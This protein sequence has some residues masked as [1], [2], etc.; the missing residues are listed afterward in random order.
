MTSTATLQM[1]QPQM[2]Q[3]KMAQMNGAP[4]LPP[5]PSSMLGKAPVKRRNSAT[6]ETPAFVRAIEGGGVVPEGE[7]VHLETSYTPIN[8]NSLQVDWYKDG[9]PVNA[10]SR[11]NTVIDRGYAVLDILYTLVEDSGEYT[12]VAKSNAGTAQS[13]PT[14]IS[15][16]EEDNVISTSMLPDQGAQ[17]QELDA[18]WTSPKHAAGSED[19][20]PK[21]APYFSVQLMPQLNLIENQPAHFETKIE[22]AGDSALKVEWYKDGQLLSSSCRFNVIFDRGFAILEIAYCFPE[23]SGD[24]YCVATNA[25][26]QAQS[27]VVQLGCAGGE[28]ILTTSNLPEQSVNHLKRFDEPYDGHSNR[29]YEEDREVAAPTFQSELGPPQLTIR[30]SA[31]ARF[32]VRV[33]PGSGDN[34]TVEWFHDGERVHTGSRILSIC[35]LG[36]V[37][38]VFQYVFAEDSGQYMCV[39]STEYG[40]VP[41]NPVTLQCSAEASI[42]TDSQLPGNAEQGI[43]AIKTLEEELNRPRENTYTYAEPTDAPTFVKQIAEP[44]SPIPESRPVGFDVRVEP[45]D[46]STMEVLWFKNGEQVSQGSRFRLD[47]DRGLA[48]LE[49]L[50]TFPEDTGEY[51]AL[52]KNKLGQMESNHVQVQCDA[53]VAIVTDS[54]LPAGSDGFKRI[55]AMEEEWHLARE[56]EEFYRNRQDEEEESAPRFDVKPQAVV[57]GEGL[58]ARFLI[59]LTGNPRPHVEWFLDDQ[60]LDLTNNNFVVANDGAINYLEIHRCQELGEMHIT[61]VAQSEK[62]KASADTT[63]TVVPMEDFRPGLK[64]V[65]RDNP[66]LKMM[67]LRHVEC[68]PELQGALHKPKPTAEKLRGVER[69]SEIKART[70]KS[71]EVVEA[72]NLYNQ[73]QSRLRQSDTPGRHAGGKTDGGSSTTKTQPQMDFPPPPP[74]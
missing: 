2:A 21:V 39:V 58:S 53:S 32:E 3:P 38:L 57:T 59:K 35:E 45:R 24:Y 34:L 71:P 29:G 15:V 44:P 49:I 72:E 27:N 17:L 69:D 8:D 74:Q 37:A 5:P 33:N 66:Y 13:A 50:Y 30:E 52:A 22:P 47:Y 1:G 40:Q 48:T 6:F 55:K 36:T 51:W 16:T 62:G 20:V 18:A 60:P 43:A 25:Y 31:P 9:Q 23:D 70:F 14:S 26:G 41:S 46:D 54:Q 64:H 7:T 19:R 73:V 28:S 67:A 56:E 10:G 65:K 63:L 12:C 11:F 42:I 68:T 4:D 61:V